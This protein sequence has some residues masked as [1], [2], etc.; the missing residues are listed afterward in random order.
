M[1]VRY[2]ILKDMRRDKILETYEFKHRLIDPK[3]YKELK[4]RK[5]CGYCHKN[6]SGR[7]P[8]IHH[9]IPIR[10]N[11]TNDRSNLMSVCSKCHDILDAES[12]KK[13]GGGDNV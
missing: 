10:F 7:I 5:K 3:I 4:A 11:G 1:G 9:I 12:E 8:E 13:Y 6:F 2:N